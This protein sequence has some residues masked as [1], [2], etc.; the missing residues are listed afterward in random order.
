VEFVALER[1]E[2]AV[3]IGKL[4]VLHCAPVPESERS[5]RGLC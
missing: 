1:R 4:V 3:L 5:V 2:A